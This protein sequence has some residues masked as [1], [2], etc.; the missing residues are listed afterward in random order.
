M[1]VTSKEDHSASKAA[2]GAL[3]LILLVTRESFATKM[4]PGLE[5]KI[6]LNAFVRC[7]TLFLN[8]F[9]MFVVIEFDRLHKKTN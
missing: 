4:E 9:C 8:L 5:N 3:N 2:I 7:F 1:I 6:R